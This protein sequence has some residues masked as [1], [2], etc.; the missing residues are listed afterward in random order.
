M[1]YPRNIERSIKK[2]Y[3]ENIEMS[4]DAE[5]DGRILGNA[6]TA[7]EKSQKVSPAFAGPDKRRI[8]MKSPITKLAAAALIFGAVMLSIHL[9]DKSTPPAYAFEQ[10][11]EAMQGKRSFHIQTYFQQRR[12]DEFWA[13]FD[14]EGRLIRFRQEEGKGPRG[15]MVTLWEGSVRS[16]YYPPPW[17]I[18]LMARVDNT[19]GGL[20][21]LEEFD[22]ET[23]VQEI[24]ALVVGG[25]AIT[26][27][28]DPPPYVDLMTIHVTRKDGKALKQ[29]LVVD[30]DTKFVVRVDDYWGRE[31]EQVFH[32]GIE[33]L[34][35][36]ETMDPRLFEP[37]F[38]EDT[39]IIDQ[40]S[41]EVGMTQAEMS[42][43]EAACEIVRQVLEAWA[44][45][46]YAKVGKLLGGAPP[47]L[48]TERYSSLQPIS[49]IS[50]GHP[51]PVQNIKPVFRV[52]CTYAVKHDSQ[53]KTVSPTFTVIAVDG[54]P[55][56]WY[57]GWYIMH[58]DL[59]VDAQDRIVKGSII[60]G[61]RVGDYTLDMSKDNV[62]KSLGK[63]NNIFYAQETYTLH[64]LPRKYYMCFESGISFLIV[65]G[66]VKEI[67][68]QKHFY[69]FTNG[70][71]VGDS[72][73]SIIQA[74]GD[75]FQLYESELKDVLIYK[76][77][78][79]TFE[80]HK[81]NRTVIEIGVSRSG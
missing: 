20:E 56:R 27:I 49:I 81:E 5:M 24:H 44:A 60:P 53:V 12:K 26:E 7:M 29:I 15:A 62:L 73:Q 61:V 50:I 22:P 30:P 13:E 72:E 64:N 37:N 46:D 25:D 31:E 35:Y 47:E 33:V 9:W 36:N 80:I 76:D 2:S 3:L 23:I 57:V 55:G 19:G 68:V 48:L 43:E 41:Q 6:L 74:F 78:G 34:E 8:I 14:E 1:R 45:A 21:G 16:Q 17:G 54:Q 11:V 79:L 51:V 63:P 38:P 18:H 66:S 75:D 10:T 59:E 67:G 32:H 65:D 42:N 39:I 70:L 4:A 69:K 77:E 40:V 58:T 28:Q 71:G 52:K